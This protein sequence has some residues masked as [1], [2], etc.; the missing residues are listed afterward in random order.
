MGHGAPTRR[1]K[2]WEKRELGPI[3]AQP[4]LEANG[5]VDGKHY[6]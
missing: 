1:P 4:T 2:H 6:D 5:E 3:G